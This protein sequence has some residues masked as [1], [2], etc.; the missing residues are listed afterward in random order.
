MTKRIQGENEPSRVKVSSSVNL[1]RIFSLP[2]SPEKPNDISDKGWDVI[3]AAINFVHLVEVS[4]L[5]ELITSYVAAIVKAEGCGCSQCR[6]KAKIL[7]EKL[8][9][10]LLRQTAFYGTNGFYSE[11]RDM[12]ERDIALGMFRLWEKE[13]DAQDDRWEKLRDLLNK[14]RK[15]NPHLKLNSIDIKIKRQLQREIKAV[16]K[17]RK[18]GRKK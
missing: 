7:T 8:D 11:E 16:R 17:K 18:K 4:S 6:K 1:L 2:Q 9:E 3:T 13:V 15:D 10:E 5:D 14:E 12:I